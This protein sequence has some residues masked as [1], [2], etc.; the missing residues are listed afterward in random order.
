MACQPGEGEVTS[1]KRTIARRNP[2]A[3]ALRQTKAKVVRSRK[4][5]T[6]KRPTSDA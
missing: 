4:A 1:R 6:R 5:Y 2:V 3:R